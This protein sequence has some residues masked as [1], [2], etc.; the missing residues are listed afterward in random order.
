MTTEQII[1]LAIERANAIIE[2]Y[3]EYE[4][5][6]FTFDR[7]VDEFTREITECVRKV[8]GGNNGHTC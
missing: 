6:C 2:G 7:M 5:R 8:E 4:L 3:T 1:Q